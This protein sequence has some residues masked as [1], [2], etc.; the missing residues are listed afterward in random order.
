M[1]HGITDLKL[2]LDNV[3]VAVAAAVIVPLAVNAPVLE[4]RAEGRVLVVFFLVLPLG[5]PLILC[6]SERKRHGST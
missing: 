6:K 2:F 4:G 5:L 3:K 1:S